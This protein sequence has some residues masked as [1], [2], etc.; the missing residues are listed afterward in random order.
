[1]GQV[2]AWREAA[3]GPILQRGFPG[4]PLPYRNLSRVTFHQKSPQCPL[5]QVLSPGDEDRMWSGAR[6]G[7]FGKRLLKTEKLEGGSSQRAKRH[8]KTP[9]NSLPLQGL[10]HGFST[11]TREDGDAPKT[12]RIPPGTSRDTPCLTR[13]GPCSCVGSSGNK[14]LSREEGCHPPPPPSPQPSHLPFAFF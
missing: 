12:S 1:M 4:P 14:P 11:P 8:P 2:E 7:F 6:K 3:P 5:S 10:P 9:Q 13:M